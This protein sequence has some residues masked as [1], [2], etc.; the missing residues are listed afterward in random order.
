MRGRHGGARR[1]AAMRGMARPVKARPAWRG[2]ASRGAAEHGW[3]TR[4]W[5]SLARPGVTRHGLSRLGSACQ[6]EAGKSYAN[7]G[8][9]RR[10]YAEQGEAGEVTP[11]LVGPCAFWPSWATRGR[12]G[13]ARLGNAGRGRARLGNARPA[14][15]LLNV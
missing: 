8:G 14:V 11:V 3:A 9:F 2:S 15:P 12:Q 10:G 5:R 1:G 6:C 13:G 7:L 4:G